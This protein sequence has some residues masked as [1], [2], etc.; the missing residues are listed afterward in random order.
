MK[1]NQHK[2][3][4]DEQQLLH[5][6]YMCQNS[7]LSL[8]LSKFKL[9]ILSI[10]HFTFS[11]ILLMILSVIMTIRLLEQSNVLHAT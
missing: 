9:V 11:F 7:I 4:S 2:S 6:N 3:E 5:Y 1:N 8:S 10:N